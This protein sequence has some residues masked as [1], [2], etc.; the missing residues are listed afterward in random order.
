MRRVLLLFYFLV[1]LE[2]S[3]MT[4]HT[5][6]A[7]Q[8]ALVHTPTGMERMP[9]Y[10]AVDHIAL[11]VVHEL[12]PVDLRVAPPAGLPERSVAVPRRQR[13]LDALASPHAHTQ[14]SAEVSPQTKGRLARHIHAMN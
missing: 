14:L 4:Q 2:L 6:I 12:R 8:L 1:K 9:K 11:E 3:E 10:L 13:S 5:S 7:L